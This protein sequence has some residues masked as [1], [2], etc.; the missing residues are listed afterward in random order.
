MRYLDPAILTVMVVV[1]AAMLGAFISV[2]FIVRHQREENRSE[3][4]RGFQKLRD[5]L[6]VDPHR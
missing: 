4:E 5:Q 3:I 6:K 2:R 1:L